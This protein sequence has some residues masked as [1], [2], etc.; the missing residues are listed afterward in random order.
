VFGEMRELMALQIRALKMVAIAVAVL[1]LAGCA[2]V[3]NPS[4]SY[5]VDHSHDYIPHRDIGAQ[6]GSPENPDAGAGTIVS[7]LRS[8]VH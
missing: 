5:E 4:D 1:S 2:S 7:L 3:S 8:L 6:P